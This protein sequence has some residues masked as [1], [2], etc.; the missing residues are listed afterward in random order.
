MPGSTGTAGAGG[1]AVTAR[2]LTL[3]NSIV[4]AN[5]APSCVGTV[6][7]GGHNI[8]FPDATCPGVNAAPKLGP[9]TDNGG[10]T[11]T[12]AL[13]SGSPALDA[14]PATGAG[15]AAT[16]QRGVTRPHGSA[17]DIGAYEQ[18]TPDLTTG[19]AASI[20]MTGATLNA[21]ITPNGA[22]ASYHFEYGTSTDYDAMTI[23]GAVTGATTVTPVSV[24]IRGLTPGTTY[25][26]RLVAA[27]A[28]GAT[29]GPDRTFTT[30]MTPSPPGTRRGGRPRILSASMSPRVFAVAP[31]GGAG[32]RR[33]KSDARFGTTLHFRLSEAAR[34][35]VTIERML[36]GR[37]S[38]R[39]CRPP[40]KH[41]RG[42]RGCTRFSTPR[43][44]MID[45]REGPNA[46]RFSGRIGHAVLE[47]GTYRATLTARD[48][49]NRRSVPTRLTFRIV[50]P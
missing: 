17:C 38:G 16:D 9:L 23:T 30:A 41:N 3:Q 1:A 26:Y 28:D 15:C 34:L 50:K 5:A 37:M 46:T 49:A 7:D 35:T 25:H 31:V 39:A 33:V 8:A 6:T 21:T 4:T 32:P 2:P 47:P 27:N 48:A 10:P 11:K 13:A 43:A 19:A 44:F 29:A 24:V 40:A 20:G 14:V 12:E 42:H 45:A 36:P 18:A 22:E